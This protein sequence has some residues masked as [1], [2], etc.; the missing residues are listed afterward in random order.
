MLVATFR[1]KS[2]DVLGYQRDLRSCLEDTEANAVK[3]YVMMINSHTSLL[4]PTLRYLKE[5]SAR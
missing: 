5:I 4:K 3:A 1:E 2:I